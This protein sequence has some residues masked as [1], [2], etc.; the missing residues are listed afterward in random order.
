MKEYLVE[1]F[2]FNDWAIR[3]I[4]ETVAALP[5]KDEPV[6]LVSHMIIAQKKWFNRIVKEVPDSSL[7]WIGQIF[8]LEE[9]RS[10]W[11]SQ[12]ERWINFLK[13]CSEADL[14]KDIVYQ[15]SEGGKFSSTVTD[16][17]LQLNYH[18]IHHRAQIMTM[19]R[20]QGITPPP[21]DYILLRRET[22]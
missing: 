10:M 2:Q 12:T 15:S 5:S 6:R 14:R 9:C 7:P 13:G 22:L 16:I 19:I 18:A 1:F 3:K 21:L 17:A 8:S 11:K 20:Q 4:L